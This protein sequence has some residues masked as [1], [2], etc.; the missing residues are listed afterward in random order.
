MATTRL[1]PLQGKE[2]IPPNPA[3]LDFEEKFRE[4]LQLFLNVMIDFE[5]DFVDLTNLMT[6]GGTAQGSLSDAMQDVFD[7]SN[8]AHAELLSTLQ[9]VDHP[10]AL[11][12]AATET[13]TAFDGSV[14][15]SAVRFTSLRERFLY[16]EE[17]FARKTGDSTVSFNADHISGQTLNIASTVSQ[18]NLGS[19]RITNLG[20]P[21]AT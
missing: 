8:Q 16:L 7:Y 12:L 1:T 13:W 4:N 15:D 19:N 10:D 2:L 6:G 17:N 3:A 5:Q 18:L 14:I 9:A 20:D 11:S 21:I